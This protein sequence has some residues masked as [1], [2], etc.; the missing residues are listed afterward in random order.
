MRQ[1]VAQDAAGANRA[2]PP[3]PF[4]DVVPGD[5]H[6]EHPNGATI[7]S[8]AEAWQGPQETRQPRTRTAAP[9]ST[10]DLSMVGWRPRF[11][12]L[13]WTAEEGRMAQTLAVET[14]GLTKR[15]S[16]GVLAVDGLDLRVR[17]GEVYGFLGPNGAGKTTTLRLLSGLLHPTSGTAIV[18]RAA[19]GRSAGHHR[20][21]GPHQG[22]EAG[23]AHRT[24]FQSPAERGRA[25]MRPR[26][27]HRQGQARRRGNRR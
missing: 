1:P 7:S 12:A 21:A 25:D 3:D 14:H 26:G 11:H 22:A 19:P 4:E 17:S 10:H 5:P 27:R 13:R 2:R 20:D 23:R 9:A 15:Y 16:T 6:T 24:A 18:A 8:A